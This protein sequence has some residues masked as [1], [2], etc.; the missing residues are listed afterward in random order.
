MTKPNNTYI[1][2]LSKGFVNLLPFNNLSFFFRIQ[3]P[4]ILNR[5]RV[6][7]E[8]Q[9]ITKTL[10]NVYVNRVCVCARECMRERVCVW[11]RKKERELLL[12]CS[13][14]MIMWINSIVSCL[15][16]SRLSVWFRLSNWPLI[17]SGVTPSQP[18]N[19]ASSFWQQIMEAFSRFTCS[20]K[21][22]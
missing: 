1:Q 14:P 11:D 4:Q 19:E 5:F 7:A 16:L 13:P 21:Q 10:F 15:R 22:G 17:C 20:F 2:F 18:P 8:K 12:A 3:H 9:K 6:S